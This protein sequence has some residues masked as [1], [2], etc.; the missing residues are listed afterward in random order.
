MDRA[1]LSVSLLRTPEDTSPPQVVAR[2]VALQREWMAVPTVGV[3]ELLGDP[4]LLQAHRAMLPPARRPRVDPIDVTLLTA[5]VKV[6]EAQT[7]DEALAVLNPPELAMALGNRRDARKAVRVTLI[8]NRKENGPFLSCHCEKRSDEAISADSAQSDR[9]CFVAALLAMT[10]G[11]VSACQWL[12]AYQRDQFLA[13]F[14]LPGGR[15]TTVA[16]RPVTRRIP[17]GT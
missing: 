2:A 15:T 10:V 3:A 14:L 9:D 11:Q 12:C 4:T 1:A 16:V 6:D 13:V 8:G 5:R 7:L 17:A